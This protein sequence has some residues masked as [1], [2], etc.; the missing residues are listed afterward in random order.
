MFPHGDG[1]LCG[2]PLRELYQLCSTSL[3]RNWQGRGC[4]RLMSKVKVRQKNGNTSTSSVV[5][6]VLSTDGVLSRPWPPAFG[7]QQH[8]DSW[9][10]NHYDLGRVS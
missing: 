1:F 7:Y 9:T 3:A 10:R 2:A 5:T 4:V 8:G 6:R